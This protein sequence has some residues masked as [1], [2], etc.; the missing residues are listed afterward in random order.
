MRFSRFSRARRASAEALYLLGDLFEVWVGDDDDNPDN[1]RACAALAAL[2]ASGV[3]VYAIHGNRDFLL[4]EQFARRTGVKLLPD[5]VLVDLYGVP[6]LL[7]HGDVFCTEDASYQQL[8]SIVRQPA[9]QRA[10][11]VAAARQRA[12]RSPAPRAP[13]ARRTPQ[14]TIPTIMDVNPEAV[15]RAIPRHRR[16]PAD[17]RPH[18]SPG[19]PSLRR[20]RRERRARRAGALVRSGELRGGRA[21]TACA[22]FRCRA[23][24]QAVSA[25]GPEWK[26]SSRSGWV[27]SSASRVAISSRRAAISSASNS[28]SANSRY[29]SKCRASERSS[30]SYRS[31][32]S[33][34][35]RFGEQPEALAGTRLDQRMHDHEVELALGLVRAHQL[36]QLARVAPRLHALVRHV[37]LLHEALDLLE[38]LELLARQ[39]RQRHAQRAVLRVREDQRQRGRRRLLLAIGMI[40]EQRR[41]ILE[42][43]LHPGARRRGPQDSTGP[44]RARSAPRPRRLAL[45][46]HAAVSGAA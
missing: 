21:P 37:E 17:P 7:S 2:T 31:R 42:R 35:R 40:H 13:A 14:R 16:A 1:A 11:P 28:R 15:L 23:R 32:T 34:G 26:R 5:P 29:I 6:T 18:A 41:Q 33:S 9:W 19:R 27:A 12:G 43:R 8:R 46:A 3:A 30:C 45:V 39:A 24:R 44:S 4:G 38:V 25:G 10:L 20:R 36:A 22:R